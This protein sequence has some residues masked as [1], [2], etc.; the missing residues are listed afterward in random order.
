MPAP[1]KLTLSKR[2]LC[3]RFDDVGT[4][5]AILELPCQILSPDTLT[6]VDRKRGKESRRNDTP[7]CHLLRMDMNRG[8][9]PGVLQRCWSHSHTLESMKAAAHRA[10][11]DALRESSRR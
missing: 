1:A 2:G 9:G 4:A 6:L 3:V 5:T 7:I 8:N 11:E 10:L